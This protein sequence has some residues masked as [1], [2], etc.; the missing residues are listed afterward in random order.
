MGVLGGIWGVIGGPGPQSWG[1]GGD[2]GVLR[3]VWGSRG[4]MGVLRK[5]LGV[6]VP[7][8]GGLGG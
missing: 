8:I 6:L 1:S 5:D 7:K 2:M 4:G 3:E